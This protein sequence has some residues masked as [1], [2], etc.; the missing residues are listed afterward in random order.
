MHIVWLNGHTEHQS[1]YIIGLGGVVFVGRPE[2]IHPCSAFG[3]SVFFL[4]YEYLLVDRRPGGSHSCLSFIF[5]GRK[6]HC[7]HMVDVYLAL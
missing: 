1:L 2:F 4:L 5:D 6:E 3:I 7:V